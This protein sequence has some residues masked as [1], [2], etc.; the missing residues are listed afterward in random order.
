MQQNRRILFPWKSTARRTALPFM[1]IYWPVTILLFLVL[2]PAPLLTTTSISSIASLTENYSHPQKHSL[3]FQNW[4]IC[5][6]SASIAFWLILSGHIA[7]HNKP[8]FLFWP[9]LLTMCYLRRR[10]ASMQLCVPKSNVVNDNK[11]TPDFPGGPVSNAPHSQCRAPGS[12]SNAPHSQ[13]RAPGSVSNTPHSQCRAPGSIPG[14]ETRF[15]MP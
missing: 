15:H 1:P 5:P 6:S 11:W 2:S 3:A 13:C 12:V 7:S 4:F 10:T 8:G 14:Q 9:L